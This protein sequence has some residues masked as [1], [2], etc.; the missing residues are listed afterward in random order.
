MESMGQWQ[1][2]LFYIASLCFPKCVVFKVQ[3]FISFSKSEMTTKAVH[4]A[5]ANLQ[6]KLTVDCFLLPYNNSKT[7]N[8][9]M[10]KHLLNLT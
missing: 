2:A 10:I 5:H 4:F 9:V 7:T 1:G 3:N 8:M 6:V